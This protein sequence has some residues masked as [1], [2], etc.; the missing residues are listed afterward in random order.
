[1]QRRGGDIGVN[2]LQSG[3]DGFNAILFNCAVAKYCAVAITA[4]LFLCFSATAIAQDDAQTATQ[5]PPISFITSSQDILWLIG[6][7]AGV[8]IAPVLIIVILI[9]ILRRGLKSKHE[10][11]LGLPKHS[12]RALLA[13]NLIVLNWHPVDSFCRRQWDNN[14]IAGNTRIC[15]CVLRWSEEH[16]D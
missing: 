11:A 6:I 4:I 3:I 5:K 12:V 10:H 13:F 16:R 8:L 9:A 15:R 7:V 2:L 1:M 14:R